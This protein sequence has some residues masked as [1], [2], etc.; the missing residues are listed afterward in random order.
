MSRW[1]KWIHIEQNANHK[2]CG[3]YKIRLVDS[4]GSPIKIPR[5]LDKDKDGILQVG[6]SKVIERRIK[7]FRGAIEGKSYPHAGGQRLSLIKKHTNFME[8]H[9]NC[10]IQYSFKK[11]P[12]EGKVKKEEELLLKCYFKKYGEVP[13]LNNN[14]PD[15]DIDWESLNC[16]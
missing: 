8:R 15:K 7:Y 9:N 13:P 3:V 4:R 2:G 14:L 1:S 16:S 11:S 12:S 10:E 6:R 5:F